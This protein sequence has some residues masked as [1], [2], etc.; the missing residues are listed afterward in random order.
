MANTILYYILVVLILIFSFNGLFKTIIIFGMLLCVKTSKVCM[1][2]MEWDQHLLA[3]L[4][5]QTI[6]NTAN[7]SK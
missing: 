4:S 3:C 2:S 1:S 5:K 7:K 6:I